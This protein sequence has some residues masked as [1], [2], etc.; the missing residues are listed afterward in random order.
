MPM[1]SS[2]DRTILSTRRRPRTLLVALACTLLLFV[3]ALVL[4]HQLDLDHHHDGEPCE[5]CLHLAPLDHG[6]VNTLALPQPM[7]PAPPPVGT[8]PLQTRGEPHTAYHSRAP[9]RLS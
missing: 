7:L 5:L 9:P 1:P 4:Q 2:R 6:L 8:P 3:Q